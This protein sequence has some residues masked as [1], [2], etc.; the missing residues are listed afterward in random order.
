MR[1]SEK[2]LRFV[3]ISIT[4]LMAGFLF[5][6]PGFAENAAGAPARLRCEYLTNPTGID[7]RQPRFQWVLANSGRGVMQTA[8]QILVASS[9]ADLAK[10]RGDVWDSGK[11]A[12]ADSAQ[13]V[14]HGKPLVSGH[15]YYWKV[16]TWDTQGETGAYSQPAQIWNGVAGAGRLERPMDWR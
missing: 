13:V 16:R 8:F 1:A 15:T 9:P 7:V 6:T 10:D 14:Y 2:F 12:S 4:L 3:L 11:V 5:L